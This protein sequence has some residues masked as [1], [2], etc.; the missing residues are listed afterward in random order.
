M[1]E[2]KYSEDH[3]WLIL[4]DDGIA[5]I[6]ISDYA[7][8]KLGDV[9]YIELPETGKQFSKD[10]ESA[11]IES[12]K[13][14]SD[15]KSP[16]SGTVVEINETLTDQPEIVNADP[17]GDGWFMKLKPENPGEIEELMDEEAYQTF[18]ADL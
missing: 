7:Q 16:I 3:E 5:T 11:V 12:V 2:L 9:V 15:I 4:N 6:G 17:I 14:A 10:E 13:A 18:I 8:Q 1:S